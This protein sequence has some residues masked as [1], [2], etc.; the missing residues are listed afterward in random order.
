[1]FVATK[2]VPQ[3]PQL[4]GEGGGRTGREGRGKGKEDG[5]EKENGEGREGE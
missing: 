2:C 4:V 3:N 5:R 1:V